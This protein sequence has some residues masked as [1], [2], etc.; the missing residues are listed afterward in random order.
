MK[1]LTAILLVY[2]VLMAPAWFH[3]HLLAGFADRVMSHPLPQGTDFGDYEA[4]GVV[5]PGRNS[6]DSCGYR[7]RFDL[8]TFMSAEETLEYY[9]AAKIE[10]VE[11]EGPFEIYVWTLSQPQPSPSDDGGRRRIIVEIQDNGHDGH[12]WDLRCW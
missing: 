9:Q 2:A 3:N 5:A 4:Q 12:G 7:V 6:K 11:G 10:P 1:V 8:H